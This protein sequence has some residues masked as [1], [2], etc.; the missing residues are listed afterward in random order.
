MKIRKI[1]VVMSIFFIFTSCVTI[2]NYGNFNTSASLTRN[3]FIIKEIAISKSQSTSVFGLFA[4]EGGLV[5]E[6]KI[7]LYKNYKL[8]KNQALAN[9]TIDI[10]HS[11]FLIFT[12]TRVVLTAD[13]VEF[14]NTDTISEKYKSPGTIVKG[15]NF[16]I[17]DTVIFENYYKQ[18]T[19][20]VVDIIDEGAIISYKNSKGTLYK[21]RISFKYIKNKK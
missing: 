15:Y 16:A 11:Y 10:S 5:R 4:K 8:K 1:L 7:K 18:T 2:Q 20:V 14:Y 21:R 13:I 19:G 12:T 9:A 3:N 6:A 17:N